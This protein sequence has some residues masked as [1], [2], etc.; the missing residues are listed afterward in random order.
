MAPE[1][2]RKGK[3]GGK[4]ES[5]SKGIFYPLRIYRESQ[6]FRNKEDKEK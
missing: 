4:L 3:G 5:I 6:L 2:E 1:E